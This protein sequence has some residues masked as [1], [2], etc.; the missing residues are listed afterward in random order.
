M[1]NDALPVIRGDCINGPRPCP[2]VGCRFH[3]PPNRRGET[4]ALDVADRGRHSSREV[5]AMMDLSRQ[6]ASRVERD[7]LIKLMVYFEEKV[8]ELVD[9][10]T[11]AFGPV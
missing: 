7:A 8:P 11:A 3:L 1:A 4:C 9:E 10:I 6:Q 2:F 5:G